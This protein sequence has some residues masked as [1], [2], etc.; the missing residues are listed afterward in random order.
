VRAQ[1]EMAIFNYLKTCTNM[2]LSYLRREQK[3]KCF[4]SVPFL[5]FFLIENDQSSHSFIQSQNVFEKK[6]VLSEKKLGFG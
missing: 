4:S 1:S 3:L 5:A 6:V 2:F